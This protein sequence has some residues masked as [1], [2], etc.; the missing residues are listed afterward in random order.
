MNAPGTELAAL[1]V[2]YARVYLTGSG[3]FMPGPPIGNA[4]IDRYIAPLNGRSE[5]IKQLVL[6]DNGIRT[7]HYA[8][9]ENGETRH[10]S[11]DLAARAVRDCLAHA[12]ARLDEVTLLCT[13]SS[14]GDTGMP[15][16]ASMLHGELGAPPLETSSHQGVC[17]AGIAA[18]RHAANAIELGAHRRA[19]VATSEFPSRLFKRS[20]FAPRG[21]DADFDAHFLR[22]MLSDGAGACLLADTPRAGGASLRLDWIHSRSFGGDYPVCMQI[23]YP[24]SPQAKSYL[25]YPS[26][27]E[28][29]RAGAF[30]LRQDIRLLPQLF[31]VGIHEYASLARA[32][33]LDPARIDH[34]LCHYSSEKFSGVVED[35]MRRAGL[36]VPRSRWFSNLSR[37]GN[38]GAAS[39]FIM[40]ADF[41]RERELADGEQVLCFV[42]ESGRFTVSFMMFT[43]VRPEAR[44]G[45]GAAEA[46]A[47]PPPHL[48]APGQPAALADTLRQL[49]ALWHEYRSRIWRTPLVR[50]ILEGRFTREDYLAWMACWIPQVREGSLW[51]RAAVANIGEP[52]LALRQ[53]ITAHA[54]DEQYD[55]RLL[56][57]DYR[58]AGG[59]AAT[60][61][62]LRRNPGGEALNSYM[63]A[64]ASAPNPVGLLGGI[65]IVEGTGQR[66]IPALLPRLRRQAGVPEKA[67]RFLKY[68]GEN[69]VRHLTR[70]LDAVGTVLGQDPAAG[71]RI[72]ATAADVAQLYAL[73]MEHVR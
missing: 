4:D 13:G 63:H 2:R 35:L 11:W 10:S 45:S 20:R 62:E 71:G 28:A 30:L 16:F 18:L 44:A 33:A 66:I 23:G 39:I 8:I 61:E 70:W 57:D 25:D 1:P 52:F 7:R 50:R 72:V 3:L 41:M 47:V 27:A 64:T 38:T 65:Y 42:P 60:I 46:E 26:L 12:G 40:L 34:L 24:K 51:M 37:R 36:H 73:Q 48:P 15:G 55:F 21:Y 29:E 56:F 54:D 32:G 14:G 22:W 69:D 59:T 43:V 6:A 19:L 5:R 31:E 17:A 67:L 68:H 53:A 49:A 58:L 9:D